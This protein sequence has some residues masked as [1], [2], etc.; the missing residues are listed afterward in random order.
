MACHADQ[1]A[2]GIKEGESR[3][4]FAEH[5]GGCIH[6]ADGLVEGV[7]DGVARDKD[8]F[9]ALALPQE[10]LLSRVKAAHVM[11]NDGLFFGE[12]GR[13]FLRMNIGCPRAQLRAALSNLKDVLK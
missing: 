10:E 1:A 5:V 11:M 9:R 6:D 2:G 7:D 12:A 4:Q 3:P 8:G 13:G